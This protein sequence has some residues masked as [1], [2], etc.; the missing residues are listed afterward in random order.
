MCQNYKSEKRMCI[1]RQMPL[2]TCS[3]RRKA[4]KKV[5][6]RWCKRISCDI[7]GV[8]TIGLC[9]SSFFPRKCVL[10]EV[11]KLGSNHT[12]KLSK[13]TWHPV[14]IQ[15]REGPSR[16]I[17]KKKKN[18]RLMSIVLAHQNSGKEHT[19]KPCTRKDAPAK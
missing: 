9:I 8:Y 5:K 17:I 13:G 6:E 2:P 16:G 3:G 4:Q 19:R 18:V 12:V 11:G 1:W 10:R 15:K 14:K 7:E